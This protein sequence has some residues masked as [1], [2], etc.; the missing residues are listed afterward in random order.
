MARHLGQL[1]PI[2][3]LGYEA[4]GMFEGGVFVALRGDLPATAPDDLL[5][6]A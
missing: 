2:D 5:E 6:Y 1:R 3:D 4:Q